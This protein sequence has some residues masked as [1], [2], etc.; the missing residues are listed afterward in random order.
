M[1]YRPHLD[2]FSP[3][4]SDRRRHLVISAPYRVRP[5][6]IVAAIADEL[7]DDELTEVADALGLEADTTSP[8][9]PQKT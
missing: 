6:A 5:V 3:H 9:S 4:F 8:E 1:V 2:R 7:T